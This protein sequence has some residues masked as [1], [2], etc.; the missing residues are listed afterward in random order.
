MTASTQATQFKRSPLAMAVLGILHL[1]PMHP[2]AIQR[3]IKEWGKDKVVNVGQRAQLYKTIARLLEAGLVAVRETGRD[4]QYPERTVY[5]ITDAGRTACL[6][7]INEMVSTPRNEFPEFP[8]ALSFLMLL[9]PDS[10]RSELEKRA[11]ALRAKLDEIDAGT[12]QARQ[13][14]L[15]RIT[16]LEDEYA[17]A[18][19]AAE[20]HWLEGV[21]ADLADGSLTWSWESLARFRDQTTA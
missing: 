2:Y 20:L 5:E 21:L 11:N 4:Q 7:W 19:T 3:R 8:A 6:A 18:V 10:A 12:A 15:P 16:L 9:S 13:Y 14:G 17:R 1:E